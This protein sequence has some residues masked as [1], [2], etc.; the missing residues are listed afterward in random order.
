M[1]AS[2]EA[3]RSEADR[4]LRSGLLSRRRGRI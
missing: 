1:K 4:K 3:I 2:G